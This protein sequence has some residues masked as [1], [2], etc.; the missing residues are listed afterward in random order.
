MAEEQR[1]NKA[2]EDAAKGEGLDKVVKSNGIFVNPYKYDG[3]RIKSA[4]EKS[5][6][7]A[8]GKKF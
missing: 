5:K 6:L 7:D 8:T 1:H 4:I 2:M 3:G